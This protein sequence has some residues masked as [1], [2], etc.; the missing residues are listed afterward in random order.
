MTNYFEVLE[1]TKK[2]DETLQR[3]SSSDILPGSITER[4]LKAVFT[5]EYAIQAHPQ[6][7]D[8]WTELATYQDVEGS[9]VEVTFSDFPDHEFYFE[10]VGKVDA[11]T[12][13]W[14]LYNI[15]DSE[16]VVG[17]EITSTSTIF[18]R[19]RSSI[20]TK[21]VG[22]KEFKIQHYLS[23]GDLATEFVNSG[24]SRVILRLP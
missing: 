4:L 2:L 7:T 5:R 10:M 16:A 12:G 18:E 9:F 11:G 13:Y 24:M 21:P 6:W 23:G 17:S 3:I 1:D 20:I 19:V 22:T 14:R 8:S 15:T